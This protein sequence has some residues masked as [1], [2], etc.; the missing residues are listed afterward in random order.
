MT[1]DTLISRE[2]L[3]AAARRA[4]SLSAKRAAVAIHQCVRL[5]VR[6]DA[7]LTFA[8]NGDQELSERWPAGEVSG[9]GAAVVDAARLLAVVSALPQGEPTVRLKVGKRGALGVRCGRSEFNLTATDGA[10]FPPPMT[11]GHSDGKAAAGGAFGEAA[12][13]G[14]DLSR[15]LAETLFAVCADDN[16]YGINGLCVEVLD[17]GVLRFVSTNG[18]RLAWSEAPAVGEMSAEGG[19]LTG[20]NRLIG[21]AYAN[22]LKRLIS[23]DAET[24]TI[25][26]GGRAVSASCG[27]TT[28]TGKLVEGEFPDYRMVLPTNGPAMQA[29]IDAGALGGAL[30]RALLMATDRNSS[31]RCAF[32]EGDASGRLV[33]S[34]QDVRMGEVVEE[35]ACDLGGR[36]IATGFNAGYLLDV[37]SAVKADEVR[38]GLNAPLDPCLIDVPGRTDCRFVVMPMRLD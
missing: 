20:R 28:L 12:L 29:T 26:M 30:R 9:E 18:S 25:R 33:I 22:E 2:A 14:A 34:A 8:G 5:E 17:G 1:L 16:R 15:V 10:D 31:I 7:L 23:S 11:L 27:D 6:G 13:T 3:V 4:A 36:G 38:L 21:R 32:S 35:L 19:K 37:L 24:W